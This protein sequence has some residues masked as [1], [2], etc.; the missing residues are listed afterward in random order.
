MTTSKQ[1]WDVT[2]VWL[3]SFLWG[4]IYILTTSQQGRLLQIYAADNLVI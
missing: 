2:E 4:K 3:L 1:S